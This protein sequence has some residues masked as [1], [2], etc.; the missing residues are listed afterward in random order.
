MSNVTRGVTKQPLD[1]VGAEKG[2]PFAEEELTELEFGDRPQLSQEELAQL[3]ADWISEVGRE[4]AGGFHAALEAHNFVFVLF[5]IVNVGPCNMI[6][7]AWLRF[8]E[9]VNKREVQLTDA[10]G[11]LADVWALQVNCAAF[12]DLCKEEGIRAFPQVRFYPR[13]VQKKAVH[14][15]VEF[16]FPAP[17]VMMSMMANVHLGDEVV[18]QMRNALLETAKGVVQQ[19]HLH[20]N[21]SQHAMFR[22]GCRLSGHL[23]V[24]RVP[25]TIHF[26]ARSAADRTLNAA[27]TNLSHTVHNLSFGRPDAKPKDRWKILELLPEAY[28]LH[29]EPLQ[30]RAFHSHHFHQGAHHYVRV[31]HTR[32]DASEHVRVYLY[33]HQWYMQTY[34]RH[35][36]PKAKI[37][38][39]ISP[40]EV[41]VE[42]RRHWYDFA[43]STLALVGG[44]YSSV[45]IAY[46]ILGVL[47][48]RALLTRKGTA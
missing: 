40:L 32:L 8:A 23:D 20:T 25:G 17:L 47:S 15:D 33:M 48:S 31:M 24:P 22:E 9:Q 46:R 2:H 10:D 14:K 3:D 38:Y 5:C 13:T 42:H 26:E 27:F 35:E 39:D 4:E 34:P 28:G 45:E 44:A 30:A 21:V 41:V 11:A 36:S 7:P 18:E 16:A 1:H 43:T 6:L 29:A 19:R 37:S 12:N